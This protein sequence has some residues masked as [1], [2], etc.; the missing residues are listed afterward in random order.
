MA[1][2]TLKNKFDRENYYSFPRIKN[3]RVI[4]NSPS[5]GFE[6][7]VPYDTEVMDADYREVPP[8]IR[9]ELNSFCDNN[10][11]RHHFECGGTE[12]ASPVSMTISQARMVAK[13][14]Q[15]YVSKARWVADP[16]D[17][18]HCCGIHVTVE[19]TKRHH[20]VINH[21]S[22]FLHSLNHNFVYEFSGRDGCG[23]GEYI[24]QAETL[25]W[26]DSE[27]WIDEE[28]YQMTRDKGRRLEVR[29]FGPRSEVL[30]PAIEFCHSVCRFITDHKISRFSIIKQSEMPS[31]M[32]YYQW[33]LKQPGYSQLKAY[34]PWSLI[35]DIVHS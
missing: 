4:K 29:L 22:R 27:D 28:D 7:E 13:V 23:S 25:G 9:E 10:G 33:L 6:W 2:V 14:L 12:F 3:K 21:M 17:D 31:G 15:H 35:D 30:I 11:F 5:I 32:E 34:A 24:E 26:C 1:T 8:E 16:E 19:P 20:N 18:N